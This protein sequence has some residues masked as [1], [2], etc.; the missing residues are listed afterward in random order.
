MGQS[1]HVLEKAVDL[2][3]KRVL[4]I[5]TNLQTNHLWQRILK[6]TLAT[7]IAIILALIPAVVAKLGKAAYLAPITTVFGHPGRRFGAMAEALILAIS[8]ALFGVAWSSLGLYLSSL[9]YDSNRPAAYTIRGVFLLLALLFHGF[10]RSHTPRLFIFV[11]LMIIVSVVD[12]TSTATSVSAMGVTQL[13]YPILLAG[14]ILFAVNILVLPEFS[15]SLLGIT[16][17]ETLGETVAALRSAGKYFIDSVEAADIKDLSQNTVELSECRN[18]LTPV[19]TAAERPPKEARTTSFWATLNAAFGRKKKAVDNKPPLSKEDTAPKTVKLK[20][21]TDSKAKLRAKLAS[22]KA[23]QT[24]CN[25]EIAYAVL[26]P[27]DLKPISDT[28]MKRLVSNTIALIGACESKYALMGDGD[29]KRASEDAHIQ[30][31]ADEAQVDH[32]FD[33]SRP[34]SGVDTSHDD[35][36]DEGKE[37][38]RERKM[39]KRKRKRKAKKKRDSLESEKEDLELVKPRKEIEFGDVELLKYLVKRI[40][41]PLS[42]LQEKIDRS[43]DVVSSCLAYCYDVPKLPSGARAPKGIELQ[44]IDIRVDILTDALAD[45]DKNSASALEGAVA[46]H[47]MEA[48]EI[49]IMPR[50][51]TFLISSF[52]LNL[53]QAALQTLEMLQQSRIIVEKRQARHGRR[54]LYA[55]RI[56]WR[57]W[58]ASGG[59][60]DSLSLPAEARQDARSGKQDTQEDQPSSDSEETLTGL[61]QDDVESVPPK[62]LGPKRAATG[63]PG[64]TTKQSRRKDKTDLIHR[65]RN[66][67]ADLLEYLSSS[68]DALYALKLTVAAF[69]VTWPALLYKWNT[70]YSLNRGLWAVLQLVLITEVAIGTSVSV[71]MLRAVGTTIGCIWGYAAYQAGNGN[72]VICV[73]I[74]VIGIVPSAYIQL[75]SKYIKAG[76]VSIVSMCIVALATVDHTVPGTATENFLKRLI[77]FL[78]GG[79]VALL[80]EIVLFP[81]KAR[82][83]LVESLASSIRQISQMEGCLAHGVESESN[84]DTHSE[85]VRKRFA[86]AKGKA[87]AALTA[88]ETFLPFC[89]N[90][91]RLKGSFKGLALVYAEILYVLRAIVD[92]MDNMLHLRQ[93][94]GSG[95]LEELNAQVYAYRRNVAGSI[96]LI[97]FAVHEALTTKLP[98]PQFLPSARLAHLRMVNRVREVI[99]SQASTHNT[100]DA[101]SASI[102][103]NMVKRIVRRKYLSW[104]AAS[105]GQIEVIEYLEELIDLTKLLVGANEFR[106]GLLTRPTYREYI[107]R[108]TPFPA[109]P[110]LGESSTHTQTDEAASSTSASTTTPRDKAINET[111]KDEEDHKEEAKDTIPSVLPP[112]QGLTK[113]RTSTFPVSSSKSMPT[114]PKAR[115]DDE[116]MLERQKIIDEEEL[117]RSLQRVRSRRMSWVAEETARLVQSKSAGDGNH[118][119]GAGKRGTGKKADKFL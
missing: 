38:K 2:A 17:I 7:T 74:L 12:L 107:D 48:P 70:W 49:D 24:E 82:D 66:G 99:S 84:V 50:M 94:Y 111:S 1:K 85:A 108:V 69:L 44:E 98:L 31:L 89:A 10:L 102:E 22:C 93:E 109:G 19:L 116:A 39:E 81:V 45:F 14:G 28:A 15:S 76:M 34:T 5:W 36:A 67:L 95:V 6:N 88:A 92:K 101:R 73:V 100:D 29:D 104:N 4:A 110:V 65:M 51:E 97:L 25:F 77:A 58:L 86:R 11:L 43:V 72:R 75:G 83:R 23:A 40:S 96:T 52:L 63:V 57:K 60:A 54:R 56:N 71:F 103:M 30:S 61:G 9:I 118:G 47:D 105:A 53:R 59:E 55:P 35:T 46:L 87:E 113:R 80:V 119:T 16:T 41:K 106:S 90:E 32:N 64:A 8:G 42:D 26:P 62:K 27:R 37:A 117:P 78:I 18:E 115:D 33:S 21:L 13:V 20:T 91:P 112:V 3:E 68:D 79:V 114:K